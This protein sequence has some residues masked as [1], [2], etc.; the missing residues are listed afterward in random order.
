MPTTV[1]EY[2]VETLYSGTG[3]VPEFWR[4]YLKK[5]CVHITAQQE[6]YSGTVLGHPSVNTAFVLFII[7]FTL[8]LRGKH[9]HLA[10]P[11]L[12]VAS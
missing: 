4:G 2:R 5:R 3:T 7:L 6:S 8:T 10:L 12:L 9:S 11:V 1:P